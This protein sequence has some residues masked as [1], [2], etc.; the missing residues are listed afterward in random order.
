MNP[1]LTYS[2]KGL[3]TRKAQTI[4][5]WIIFTLVALGLFASLGLMTSL[6][7]PFEK[8]FEE[9][10]GGHYHFS[11]SISDHPTAEDYWRNNDA[12][13]A[14][15]V[16]P[17]I[18]IA[19]N[20]ELNGESISRSP[21]VTENVPRSIELLKL[22]E[23]NDPNGPKAGEM[24]ISPALAT[25]FNIKIGD[26]ITVP[27][28]LGK[29][30][31]T[32][33]GIALDPHFST[34]NINPTRVWV[35]PGTV[36]EKLDPKGDE[37]TM[38][39]RLKSYDGKSSR[40]YWNAFQKEMG[41]M[42]YGMVLNMD[43]TRQA[44]TFVLQLNGI[45]MMVF[46]ILVLGVSLIILGLTMSGV[47]LSEYRQIGI[48]KAQGFSSFQVRLAYGIQMMI[49]AA[50]GVLVGF[51]GGY[52]LMR[53][54]VGSYTKTSGLSAA[55][56]AVVSVVAVSLLI[57][58]GMTVFS[59]LVSTRSIGKIRPY[60]AIQF[61][62]PAKQRKLHT[63]KQISK[64]PLSI[65]T[66]ARELRHEPRHALVIGLIS[67]L[68]VFIIMMAADCR[69]TMVGMALKGCFSG[70][71]R[72]DVGIMIMDPTRLT[73]AE[74]ID[75]LDNNPD[76]AAHA[77]T[78]ILLNSSVA[79]PGEDIEDPLL[80]FSYDEKMDQLEFF[81]ITGRVPANP[82]EIA[83]TNPV[84]EQLGLTLGDYITINLEKHQ[85][86]LLVVGLFETSSNGGRSFMVRES[87]LNKEAIPTNLTHRVRLKDGVD[88]EQWLKAY[89][90]QYGTAVTVQD[91]QKHMKEFSKTLS[92]L[93]MASSIPMALIL[94]AICM[95]TVFNLTVIHLLRVQQQHG[96][97]LA[98]GRSSG[99]IR[100]SVLFKDL[101]PLILG[102]FVGM[103][104]SF[105]AM[106]GIFNMIFGMLG[107]TNIEVIHS[108]LI[109]I[110]AIPVTAIPILFASWMTSGRIR[111]ISPRSLIVD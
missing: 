52:L 107:F 96:I 27:G 44:Y 98:L 36:R 56:I 55:Q 99:S 87:A 17:S 97:W 89:M 88:S 13:E 6:N 3:K 84:A 38:E 7:Q 109:V 28:K 39:I 72:T 103:G 30:D 35:A 106:P 22:L 82:Q 24:W 67:G 85:T 37:Q 100:L 77:G 69:E 92:T 63:S 43:T 25:S 105:A 51:P 19:E 57:L 1:I 15:V 50:S 58:L 21:V 66:G 70:Q 111:K 74:L 34:T 86:R 45:F 11:Y 95:V 4:A 76:V 40:Q 79:L 41:G 14:V 32:V 93:I 31:F 83:L 110:I 91:S 101:L 46:A 80:G 26:T 49:M 8:M 16:M 18:S 47:I 59:A 81:N 65:L 48:L 73:D 60:Q 90:D 10:K 61:G 94:I 64:L 29:V 20:M 104:V 33:S 71:E 9:A 5:L 2:I 78:R 12:V 68:L 42:V 108:T 23:G 62:T 102:C 54:L 75:I 53:A